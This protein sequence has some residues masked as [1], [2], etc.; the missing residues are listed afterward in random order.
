ME[1]TKHLRMRGVIPAPSGTCHGW[2]SHIVATRGRTEYSELT[3][4]RKLKNTNKYYQVISTQYLDKST[5]QIVDLKR[6]NEEKS[7][8]LIGSQAKHDGFESWSRHVIYL[9]NEFTV[10]ARANSAYQ[11]LVGR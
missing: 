6:E 5:L 9:G 4:T 2:D 1:N 11:S 8:M 7:T 10:I 3:S